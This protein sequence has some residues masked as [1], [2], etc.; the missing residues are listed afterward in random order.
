MK[1]ELAI[2]GGPKTVP[3]GVAIPWPI[4]TKEDKQAVMGVLDR[5]VLFGVYAP[6]TVG[7]E[8]E[9]AEFIG[10]PY[11]MATGSGTSA[12]HCALWAV[13]VGPG[14]EVITSAFSF[15]G[16]FHPILQQNAIP[17]FV[18]IDPR[19]Y[20]IDVNQIEAKITEKTKALLPVHIH[21]VPADMDEIMNLAIK[22][23]LQVVEDACQAHGSKYKG[24]GAGTI[25]HAGAFSLNATKN[26]S[27][28]EGGLLVTNDDGV[29]YRARQLRTF[30]EDPEA[31]KAA[32][33]FRPYTVF[34][35]GFQ[36][37]YQEMPAAFAR[38]QLKRL[39]DVNKNA[40]ANGAYLSEQLAKIRGLVPP[41]VPP[42]RT[43]IYHKYRVRFQPDVLGLKVPAR[44]FRERL[45]GALMAEGV[46]VAIW[47]LDPLPAFPIFQ[48]QIGWGKGCPWNC[49]HYGREITYRRE[50]Y[51]E[52]Q[53]ML[54]ESI[55][56]GDESFP[57]FAQ[58]RELIDYYIAAF[59]KVLRDP[60]KLLQ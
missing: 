46:N 12:I 28:G 27:G 47:H 26:L 1:D 24:R 10:A 49:S 8:K 33:T 7:L 32:H 48:K 45:F 25:G 17:V 14:D 4:I 19:T 52:T 54:D 40:Q 39:P 37:R 29:Y 58:K 55:I 43:S 6:E 11:A 57:L 44:E 36:Y 35:P 2:N 50:D 15:S 13:G 60:E 20:N 38:S 3:D 56:I 23:N 16:S 42:D 9:F 31:R 21:G 5:A 34:T 22:Y 30:G 41:Y 59:Q 51:P 53:K 18:D